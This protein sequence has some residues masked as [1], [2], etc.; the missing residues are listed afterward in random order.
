MNQKFLIIK[1]SRLK[2][3]H[4]KHCWIFSGSILDT[5]AQKGDIVQVLDPDKNLLAYAFFTDD[6]SIK[7]KIFHFSDSEI[8][9]L[10]EN[11]WSKKLSQALS[12]RKTL[13]IQSNAFRLIFAEAD[14]MPGLIADVYDDTLVLLTYHIGIDKIFSPL[15]QAFNSLGFKNIYLKKI[16]HDSNLS[17]GWITG[18]S[19]VPVKIYEYNVNFLVDFI[20]GQKTGFYLDQRENRFLLQKYAPGKNVLNLCSYTGGFSL[21]ALAAGANIVHS[22]DLSETALNTL[23][24][25]I[26]LNNFDSNK[27]QAFQQDC[28]NFLDSA[29]KNFYDIIILDPPAFAKSQSSVPNAVKG[30]RRLNL[31]ALKIIR[32]GGLIFTFSCS[33]R[34][35]PDLFR[36]IIFEA[37]AQSG[38]N[39]QII[40]T[41]SHATDHPINIFHPE[42]EYLKGLVL[43]V[44]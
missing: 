36:K 10:S 20:N 44:F 31:K 23:N 29:Q 9:P 6:P 16:P 26:T 1:K 14:C 27:H 13:N 42:T 22:V 8:S 30:Y 17:I 15:I 35:T 5:N 32:P 28:F 19:V 33:Q 40:H 37:S 24:Q 2:A 4:N 3:I 25:N 11:F 43:A 21:H 39:I 34:I 7:A 12:L 18:K 41:L 38:R